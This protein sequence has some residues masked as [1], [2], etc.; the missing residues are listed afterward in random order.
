MHDELRLGRGSRVTLRRGRG[1]PRGSL[2]ASQ[3]KLRAPMCV[4]A[5][6][7]CLIANARR[8]RMSVRQCKCAPTLYE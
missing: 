6:H 7:D 8:H 2:R 1:Q 4:R 5:E 3:P